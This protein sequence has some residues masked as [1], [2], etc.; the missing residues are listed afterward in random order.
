MNRSFVRS[1]VVIAVAVFGS[2]VVDAVRG[3][4]RWPRRVARR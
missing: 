2:V 3:T 1:V 4:R